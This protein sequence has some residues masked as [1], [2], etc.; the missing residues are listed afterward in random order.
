MLFNRLKGKPYKSIVLICAALLACTIPA[1]A[2]DEGLIDF[3]N[4]TDLQIIGTFYA[5]QGVTFNNAKWYDWVAQG[6]TRPGASTDFIIGGIEPAASYPVDI[7]PQSTDP[8]IAVFDTQ[9]T[10]VCITAIDVGRAGARLVAFDP[11]GSEI[12]YDEKFGVTDTGNGEYYIL[13]VFSS[14]ANIQTVKF[15]QPLYY[16]NDGVLWDNLAFDSCTVNMPDL[17]AFQSEWLLKELEVGHPLDADFNHSGQVDLVDFHYLANYWL[18]HC[19]LNWP[20]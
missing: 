14:Q 17:A 3:D 11:N 12:D 6:Q 7:Y 2:A 9:K 16:V 19:P 10:W 13:N 20:W 1:G 18:K 15:Y 8:I 5:P 4:G